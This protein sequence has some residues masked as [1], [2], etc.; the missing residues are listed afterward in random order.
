[1]R[2]E[3]LQKGRTRILPSQDRCPFQERQGRSWERSIT[4]TTPMHR[5]IPGRLFREGNS[6]TVFLILGGGYLFGGAAVFPS[7]IPSL[8]RVRWCKYSIILCITCFAIFSGN[9][10]SST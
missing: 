1:M 8:R 7:E 10:D 2:V 4:Q 9:C 5:R 6:S 3:G